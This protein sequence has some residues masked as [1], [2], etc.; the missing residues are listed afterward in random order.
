MDEHG[1]VAEAMVVREG[2]ILYVGDDEGT[3]TYERHN[4]TIIDLGGKAVF[5]GFHDAH[6]HL[7]MGGT[8]S[9]YVD[10]FAATTVDELL[11]TVLTWS[12]ENPDA[13]WVQ[14]TGWNMATFEG[15]LS[16]SMLDAV[17]P[18]RPVFLYSADGH[19]A[20]VNSV[21]L[22]LAGVTSETGVLQEAA[23]DPVAELI[24]PYPTDKVDQGLA[25]GMLEANQFGI[26]TI[27]DASVQD[28]MLA[29]YARAEAQD[30]LT[31]RVHSAVWLEPD[32][33]DD[34][35]WVAALRSEYSSDRVAVD[36]VKFFV[37]GIIESKT[38]VMLEPYTDGTNGT[39][40]Y[41]DEE[42]QNAAI[43]LDAMGFQLHAH[44]IGDGATRQFLDAVEAVIEANGTRDRRPQLAHLEVVDPADWPRFAELG[45]YANFQM[46]WAYPDPYIQDLTWPVIGEQRS[47]YLYP[48]GALRA[49]GATIVAGSDWSVSSMNPFE[50]IEVAVSRRDPWT[51]DGEVLTPEHRIDL[52][53]AFRAYTSQGA[54]ATFSED[55]VGTLEVG[56]RA[57]FVIVD[58]DPF[59]IPV[60]ELSEVQVEST[61]LD[62][63]VVFERAD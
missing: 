61:W 47:K 40:I 23:M 22:E 16:K 63:E 18:D 17:V 37:D 29:G 58:R 21:A 52:D 46:L 42:L 31:L 10:L 14:G 57:D 54:K 53:T 36:S 32:R 26:T 5:P 24:P 45:A 44:V 48:I 15:L 8:D 4:A 27:V 56:K 50:A 30:S 43:A 2:E 6:T 20:F 11:D 49:A 19:T 38:A 25:L 34:L 28:W 39:P 33:L 60:P 13:A 62:G 7:I 35:D 59:E 12:N 1:T 41:S 55:L 51:N 3:L 9:F